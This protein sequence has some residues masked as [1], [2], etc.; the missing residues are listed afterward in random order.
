MDEKLLYDIISFRI[1]QE[2]KEL[3]NL[4]NYGIFYAPELYIAFILGK[5]IKKYEIEIFG[6]KIKWERELKLSTN[7]GPT[8][9]LFKTKN[10][11]YVFE[12]KLRDTIDAYDA[13]VKKLQKLTDKQ[14]KK[15]F[16]AL[17][18][19]W[20]LEQ[21]DNRIVELEMKNKNLKRLHPFI[22]FPTLQNW[23]KKP[24]CCTI[25]LWEVL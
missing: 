6:E 23:Y 1:I 14:Y 24:V 8:D 7:S 9:F 21:E 11:T 16:L 3:S 4:V 19:T 10:T 12:L 25:G 18:D 5:Y 22:S 15:Y 20:C 17:I 13:D 2:D